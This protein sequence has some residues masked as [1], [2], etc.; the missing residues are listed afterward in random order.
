MHCDVIDCF[1]GQTRDRRRG[2]FKPIKCSFSA[3]LVAGQSRAVSCTTTVSG[4]HPRQPVQLT[5]LTWVSGSFQRKLYLF[6]LKVWHSSHVAVRGQASAGAPQFFA[7]LDLQAAT[8][9]WKD[10]TCQHAKKQ[11]TQRVTMTSKHDPRR[12]LSTASKIDRS[13]C[14]MFRHGAYIRLTVVGPWSRKNPAKAPLLRIGLRGIS[15][16]DRATCGKSMQLRHTETF[17]CFPTNE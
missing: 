13:H 8:S 12:C 9:I 7:G 6:R 14:K 2:K 15:G 16:S 11:H 5:E 17:V 10:P 3:S 4:W 1:A